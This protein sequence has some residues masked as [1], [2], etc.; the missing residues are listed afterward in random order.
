M[1]K[2]II[3]IIPLLIITG[4]ESSKNKQFKKYAKEYYETYMKTINNVDEVTI[5]LG[6][7]RNASSEGEYKLNKLKK[8]EANSKITFEVDK[9]TKELKNEKIE[10][11]CK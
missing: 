11:K 1:K 7:L 2:I 9:A 4:C 8:C 6:D 10:L 5:T 3:L